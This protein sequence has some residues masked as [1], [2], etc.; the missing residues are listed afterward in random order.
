MCAM[1]GK[2]NRDPGPVPGLGKS[3]CAALRTRCPYR[4]ERFGA[5]HPLSVLAALLFFS[6]L[7]VALFSHGAAAA[8]IHHDLTVELKPR[9]HS[10]SAR[11]RV[12]VE[13]PDTRGYI[14]LLS[15]RARIKSVL[16]GGSEARFNFRSGRLKV[17][18]DPPGTGGRPQ[19]IDISYDS[20]F[21]DRVPSDIAS[22]DNPGFGVAATISE[23]GTFLLPDSG[24]YP[25][26]QPPP[27][28]AREGRDESS[29][30]IKIIAPRGVYAVTAGGLAGMV[31]ERDR[32]ITTWKV[33]GIRQGLSLSAAGYSIRSDKTAKVPVYT[34]FFPE[35]DSLSQ[36]YLKASASYI[37][38][39]S[40]L[41]GPYGFP[42]FA[43]VENFFPT[44]YGFPSYT[45]LG[46]T[47][48]RL[49]FIPQTSLRHE[50]AHC[51]WGNGVLVDYDSG[52]WSEGLTTYVADYLSTELAS[53]GEAR[54]YR[55]RML[56]DYATLAASG[57]DFPLVDFTSRTD[58][59]TRAVGYGKAAFVFHMIRQKLGDDAF[60]RSLRRIYRERFQLATSWED[61]RKV[62]V[63]E[64]GWD[65]SGS[66]R[67]FDQWLARSGAPRLGLKNVS[68][69][70]VSG[71]WEVSGN[72][73]QGEPR[74]D[75]DLDIQLAASG[76][77]KIEKKLRVDG[78]SS[79]FVIQSTGV[80]EK[81]TLDP[82]ANVFRLL[83]PEEIPATVNSLKGSRD[84]VAVLCGG[85]SK[86][87]AGALQTLLAGLDQEG[88]A[89]VPENEL[90][91]NEIGKKDVLLFGFPASERL[92]GLLASAPGGLKISA[93]GFSLGK[94]FSSG[95]ADCLFV[96]W[97]DPQRGG[98]LTALFTSTA[99]SAAEHAAPAARKITHYGR[100]SYLAFS[101][102]TNVA[103]GTWEITGSPLIVNFKGI[104]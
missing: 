50:V 67:F 97:N 81:L 71:G 19:A 11:D 76:A 98:K 32:S 74:F 93:G 72:V 61:F 73:V 103:K 38:F 41:H 87:K 91:F 31:D 43:V 18:P 23:K 94:S 70:K 92:R 55:L 60:W 36:T 30:D 27:H 46:A 57:R 80:P 65:E 64:G 4:C 29:F 63:A 104:H 75:L 21:D 3:Y 85:I 51:W 101:R 6:A 56:R 89:I 42:K 82:G 84:L 59:A 66:K 20:V 35:S 90:D 54:E 58:P 44:G 78:P 2:T 15:K 9:S 10:L 77:E 96:V 68:A 5:S 48:L 24:W 34:F 26:I 86:E 13:G 39:Y 45:L 52:N 33:G 62:F 69:K 88:A 79:P 12:V 22:F 17:F 95:S 16:A 37:A 40:H 83:Y 1:D 100:Y 25:Q 28:A 53:A 7:P 49:P 14:F 99:G 47:V 102:G 8:S